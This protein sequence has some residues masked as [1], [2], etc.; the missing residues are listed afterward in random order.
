MGFKR[1]TFLVFNVGVNNILDNQNLITGGFEQLR[2]D[3]EGKNVDKFPARLFYG[4][5]VNYF[6]SATFRF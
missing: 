4:F 6:A 5:G 3:Y 2:F 1:N